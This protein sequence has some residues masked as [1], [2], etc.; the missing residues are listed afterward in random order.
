MYNIYGMQ[1]E[2]FAHCHIAVVQRQYSQKNFE[3]IRL[4]KSMKMKIVYDLDDDMWSVPS[5]NPAHKLLRDLLPGFHTCARF[6]D[7]VTV[8]TEHLKLM[9]RREMGKECPRVESVEN[10]LDFGWFHPLPDYLRKK[11]DGKVIVGWAGTNT[12][13]GDVKSVFEMIPQLMQEIPEMRFELVGLPMPDSWSPFADRVKVR[14][15]I[16]VAEFANYWASW[17]WDI[18][19]APLERNK[20]NLSKSS[21]KML[22]A[23][24]LGVPCVSSNIASYSEFCNHS[25]LLRR[26]VMPD[27]TLGWK[28][29]IRNLVKDEKLRIEVGAEMLRVGKEYYDI[30]KNINRWSE[31]FDSL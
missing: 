10:S 17:Q 8:S 1:P 6:C 4:L 19:L 11:K 27:T 5:Y 14:D 20:F 3:A 24:S 23:A 30:R 13:S 9:V 7:V 31:I 16:P 15:Y 28:T 12:H 29:M 26:T 21:I 2:K 18:A 25:K 22:E